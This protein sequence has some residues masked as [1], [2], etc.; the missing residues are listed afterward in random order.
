MTHERGDYGAQEAVRIHNGIVRSALAAHHGREVKHTGDGIMASFPI[1]VNA[2]RAAL[3]IQEN[4]R[5]NNTANNA[6]PVHIRVGL[7][8][9][10][11]VE[12]EDDFFG[13]TVQIAARVCDK[14]GT[15]EIFITENVRDLCLGQGV[16][17]EEAGAF[18]MKGV[19]EPMMLFRVPVAPVA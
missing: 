19:P 6:I 1:A 13:T 8:A 12:E 2:A 15:D 4:L 3:E 11:A 9:G 14:A 10:E 16:Y 18:E 17:V 5:A 7:N